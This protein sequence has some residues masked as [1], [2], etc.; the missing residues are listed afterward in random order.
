V[1]QRRPLT[2]LLKGPVPPGTTT[3]RSSKRAWNV[4]RSISCVSKSRSAHSKLGRSRSRTAA[5]DRTAPPLTKRGYDMAV[6]NSKLNSAAFR[7]AEAT[8]EL[9]QGYWTG[10]Y[11]SGFVGVSVAK[12]GS[13]ESGY[14]RGEVILFGQTTP[15][16]NP[17]DQLR[18][19]LLSPYDNCVAACGTHQIGMGAGVA[20]A[21]VGAIGVWRAGSFVGALAVLGGAM[22][23]AWSFAR[24]NECLEACDNAYPLD[25]ANAKKKREAARKKT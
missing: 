16:P 23:A 6:M 18:G 11:M 3:A 8:P 10:L 15:E 9:P 25:A 7:L 20:V 1:K 22:G 12:P 2:R 4:P 24:Y 21:G 19:T 5:Q 14:G 13:R 17:V